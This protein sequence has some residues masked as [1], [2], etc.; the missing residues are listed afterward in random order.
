MTYIPDRHNEGSNEMYRVEQHD[1][2]NWNLVVRSFTKNAALRLACLL[3]GEY[4]GE[5]F[6]IIEGY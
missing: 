6:R 4:P 1:G 5:A 3:R 2:S